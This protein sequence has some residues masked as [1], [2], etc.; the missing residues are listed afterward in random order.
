MQNKVSSSWRFT[1]QNN[2]L[3]CAIQREIVMVR[4]TEIAR[5]TEMEKEK[6]M[7]RRGNGDR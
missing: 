3:F 7:K 4:K 5:K 6:E 2:F 1:F